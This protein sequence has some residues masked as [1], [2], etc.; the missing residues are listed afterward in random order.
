MAASP[1]LAPSRALGVLSLLGLGAWAVLSVAVGA[2]RVWHAFAGPRLTPY[3]PG[4]DWDW[5]GSEKIALA[6]NVFWFLSLGGVFLA[7]ILG[8]AHIATVH[9]QWWRAAAFVAVCVAGPV[10]AER[11]NG[12]DENWRNLRTDELL[13][14]AAIIAIAV[15]TMAAA[16]VLLGVRRRTAT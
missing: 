7:A 15:L 13:S 10:G 2:I 5:T 16:W 8:V 3:R 4:Q 14:A 6:V 9:R 12:M 1:A 11:V